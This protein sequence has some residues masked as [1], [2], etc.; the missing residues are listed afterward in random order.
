MNRL[1][2]RHGQSIKGRTKYLYDCVE[3]VRE[4]CHLLDLFKSYYHWNGILSHE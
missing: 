1:F 2:H 3:D 4:P